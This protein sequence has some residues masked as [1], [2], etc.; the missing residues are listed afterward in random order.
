MRRI[1]AC[2]ALSLA[3]G[4]AGVAPELPAELPP[5]LPPELPGAILSPGGA[6]LTEAELVAALEQAQIVVLGEVHDNPVHHARQARL[7]RPLPP[8]GLAFEM[9]PGSSQAGL[10]VLLAQ[11]RAPRPLRP[12]IGARRLRVPA[13]APCARAEVTVSEL[14]EVLGQSRPRVSRHLRLLVEAGLLKRHQEGNWAYYRLNEA[15][16]NGE[17]ARLIVDL[18]AADDPLHAEDL[19]RLQAVKE[20]WAVKTAADFKKNEPDGARGSA[21]PR[22]RRSDARRSPLARRAAPSPRGQAVPS[23]PMGRPRRRWFARRGVAGR[24][25]GRGRRPCG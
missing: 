13:R 21:P 24:G 5:E 10:Q 4:C 9:V 19:D 2:I 14:G 1:L 11:R 6:E 12:A 7:V 22:T 17:L 8:R 16:G 18:M 25:Y 3:T 20:A 15:L 23:G